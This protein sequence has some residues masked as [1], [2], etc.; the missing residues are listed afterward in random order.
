[1]TY[2]LVLGRLAWVWPAPRL[3]VAR[4]HA[5]T[6]VAE[7]DGWPRSESLTLDDVARLELAISD[8]VGAV[9]GHF[10]APVLDLG[11]VLWR[12]WVA[13]KVAFQSMPL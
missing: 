7:L 2:R 11:R 8:L 4:V 1:M 6:A 3:D 10:G 13:R 9:Q 12:Q 5:V